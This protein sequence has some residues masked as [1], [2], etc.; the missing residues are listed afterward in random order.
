[1]L[2]GDDYPATDSGYHCPC[3]ISDYNAPGIYQTG[4]VQF[5]PDTRLGLQG[6]VNFPKANFAMTGQ[7]VFR[8][9]RD[10]KPNIEWV[11][12]EY[13][14]DEHTNLQFGRK[15]LP[16]F[17]YSESQ[18]VGFSYPWVHLPPQL[19]GWEINNYD[20]VNLNYTRQTGS[21]NHTVE[22]FYGSE[23]HYDSGYW[24]IYN[25]RDSKTDSKWQ[26]ILGA[27]YA[28]SHDWLEG[29]LLYIQSYTQNRVT[30]ADDPSLIASTYSDP[31]KQHIYGLSLKADYGDW[32]IQGELL[33][34]NRKHDYG[35]DHS[36][37]VAL[38]YHFGDWLPLISFAN[39]KQQI[40]ASIP[41]TPAEG[42]G[43][44]SAVLRYDFSAASDFKI[45]FDDWRDHTAPGYSSMHGNWRLLSV[46]YDRVF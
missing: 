27:D 39:Y 2:G 10:G 16:L 4:G 32:V 7:V 43:T 28:F 36:Q 42:H 3:F 15:R 11:Y 12:G 40:R 21:W 33:Y 25:G 46:S 41:D 14:F 19:Y 9:S 37:L 22:V 23:T 5:K 6:R 38:G 31:A 8:G 45:E 17:Y 35:M 29:R 34:I 1:M 30:F 18:D 20:G 26:N 44:F 24:K 13:R